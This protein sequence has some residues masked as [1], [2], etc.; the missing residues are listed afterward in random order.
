MDFRTRQG[1]DFVT[2]RRGARQCWAPHSLA[3][4][5]KARVI[6]QFAQGEAQH[7]EAGQGMAWQSKVNCN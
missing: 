4:Q 7:S 3:W 1:R 2:R 6:N 5:S